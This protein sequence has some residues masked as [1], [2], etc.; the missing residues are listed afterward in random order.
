M[1]SRYSAFVLD[2]RDLPARKLHPS[3]RP[4]EAGA[5]EPGTQWL[6]LRGQSSLRCTTP[7]HG[8]DPIRRPQQA[9][10]PAV[11]RIGRPS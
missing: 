6:G 1:R 11:G 10:L 2:L 4:A 7:I 8:S 5:P 3:T 9:F